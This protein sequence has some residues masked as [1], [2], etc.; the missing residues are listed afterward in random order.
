MDTARRRSS[1]PAISS[2]LGLPAALKE[3]GID[4]IHFDIMAQK[5]A[6]GCVG[7]YVPL[8]KED[9]LSIFNAAR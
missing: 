6:D 5:A 8:S 2:A 3:V 9:I 1:A 7:S 4:D